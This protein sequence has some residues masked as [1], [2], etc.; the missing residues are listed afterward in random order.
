[1]GEVL[2]LSG[3]PEAGTEVGWRVRGGFLEVMFE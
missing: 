2:V 3:E 1:M